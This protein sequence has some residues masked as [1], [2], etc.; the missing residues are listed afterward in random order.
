VLIACVVDKLRL[1][2]EDVDANPYNLA[3]SV[4][5]D[6][7][8]GFVSEKGQAKLK[9]HVLVECRGK[10]EDAELELEFRRICDGANG[11]GANLPFDVI[12][13]DKKTN[14]AGLQFADLVA[15]P[16]GIHYLRPTQRNHAY[17]VLRQ[18]FLCAGGRDAVGR[19]F[20]GV[21]LLVLP[22]Q[23]AKSPGD[24]TEAIAPIGNPQST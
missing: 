14:L 10:K 12:F 20:E 24:P 23:K 19:A 17:D 9:T 6:A 21:G 7:L 5:L 8:H 13:A 4:C 3:L 11:R 15:R 18:K 1:V 22:P 2:G 16:I